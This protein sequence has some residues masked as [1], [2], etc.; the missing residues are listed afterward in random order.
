[1]VTTLSTGITEGV[2]PAL[3]QPC[4]VLWLA[5]VIGVGGKANGGTFVSD[6]NLGGTETCGAQYDKTVIL[7]EELCRGCTGSNAICFLAGP[8]LLA[9]DGHGE[10]F[11]MFL[12]A[13]L[14]EGVDRAAKAAVNSG[15]VG[16]KRYLDIVGGHLALLTP[17]ADLI[18]QICETQREGRA[19]IGISVLWERLTIQSHTDILDH[20]VGKDYPLFERSPRGL[21]RNLVIWKDGMFHIDGHVLTGVSGDQRGQLILDQTSAMRELVWGNLLDNYAIPTDFSAVDIFSQD[22]GDGDDGDG[23]GDAGG[24]PGQAQDGSGGSS[25]PPAGRPAGE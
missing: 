1:M 18:R 4:S 24:P 13:R 10:I 12:L 20:L 14:M 22:G 17:I 11:S 7:G 25:A 5:G 8:L 6:H 23:D 3:C 19:Y 2:L 21:D 15:T 9:M 16:N